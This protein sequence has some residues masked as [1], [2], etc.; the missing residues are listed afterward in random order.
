MLYQA[1]ATDYDG[2]IATEGQVDETTIT[3]LKRWQKTGRKLILVTGRRLDNLY[4]VFPQAKSFDCIV[5]ENGALLSF[6]ST[7]ETTLL[8]ESPSESLIKALQ[9]RQV[10]PLS[11][12]Q[13][14]ISTR[15][16][17]D[18]TVLEVI[19][20]LGLAWLI[21]YNKGAVMLLPEGVDKDSGL[22]IALER[23][24]LSPDEVVAVGD[25]ENDLPLLNLCGL[26]VSVKNALPVLKDCSDWVMTKNRGEGV[27]ELIDKLF[28]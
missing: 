1:L 22:R 9:Q 19:K 24:N 3:A 25:G 27:V 18:T 16:P 5:A 6:P 13:G 21:S 10:E 20:E 7:G 28:Q 17:H 2:T 23:M 14:I 11:V 15:I 4:T 8:G 12:G 26:S